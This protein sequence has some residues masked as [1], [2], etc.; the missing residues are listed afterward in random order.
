MDAWRDGFAEGFPLL[1]PLREVAAAAHGPDWPSRATMQRALDAA[2]IRT[3]SGLPL[4]LVASMVDGLSYEQ[5][6]FCR[7]ELEFR[8]RN[9]HDLFNVLVWLSFP[10]AKAALNAR[11]HAAPAVS[12]GRG[13]VRDALTLFDESG[14]IVLSA[15][16]H[17]LEMIRGFGWKELFWT[18]RA[19]VIDGMLCLPFGH[20]LCEKAL[21]PYKGMTGHSLLFTVEPDFFRLSPAAQLRETDARVAV[22]LAD[23]GAILDTRELAPLPLLGIPGWCVAN[24]DES[25]YDDRQQFRLGRRTR[26]QRHVSSPLVMKGRA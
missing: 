6:L 24:G 1:W 19:R 8:E 26:Q 21:S 2:G 3:T 18:H 11:H 7:G 5:R 13:P 25:Y 10:R 15:D 14:L 17:L 23:P 4:R 16:G 22:H 12:L 20:A 9:W